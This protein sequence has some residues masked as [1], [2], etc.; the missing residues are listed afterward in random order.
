LYQLRTGRTI[1]R[2]EIGDHLPVQIDIR[3]LCSSKTRK[4]PIMFI[5]HTCIA[6]FTVI[7][8]LT[9][10]TT[11]VEANSG[12]AAGCDGNKAAIGGRHLDKAV[13]ISGP[14]SKGSIGVSMQDVQGSVV[15]MESRG[16]TVLKLDEEYKLCVKRTAGY[17]G[18]LIR[19]GGMDFDDVFELY[20]AASYGPSVFCPDVGAAGL[21]HRFA[22]AKYETCV[23]LAPFSRQNSNMPVDITV[24]VRN[25]GGVSEFYW[26]RFYVNAGG[27][28]HSGFFVRWFCQTTKIIC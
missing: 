5:A 8:H 2:P 19:W 1:N 12:G 28:E 26:D 27:G 16:L 22:T 17:K 7:L 6:L 20:D 3:L 14:L 11:P 13:T 18:I 23:D 10:T 15:P 9:S 25:T 24:V 4:T 21:T